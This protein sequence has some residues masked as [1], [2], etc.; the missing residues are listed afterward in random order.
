MYI[1]HAALSQINKTLHYRETSF[2]N[3]VF[4]H[5]IRISLRVHY[6]HDGT[7]T[8]KH[9]STRSKTV[10]GQADITHQQM[11]ENMVHSSFFGTSF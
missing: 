1:Y 3:F 5:L 8:G 2:T 11:L 6:L 10:L 4:P 9:R 7:Y